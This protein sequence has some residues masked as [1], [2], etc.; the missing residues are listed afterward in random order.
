MGHNVVSFTLVGRMNDRTLSENPQNII[1]EGDSHND[2]SSWQILDEQPEIEIMEGENP[3]QGRRVGV[4]RPVQERNEERAQQ[5]WRG[6]M[7]PSCSK[8][9]TSRSGKKQCQSCDKYT[10]IRKSC[11]IAAENGTVFLCKQC[12]PLSETS[13]ESSHRKTNNDFKCNVCD[14][15]TSFRYNLK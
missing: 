3:Y 7:C 4:S 15:V 13:E 1:E 10:H 11:I 8:G 12:K 2:I 5:W 6:A 9:F 14:F